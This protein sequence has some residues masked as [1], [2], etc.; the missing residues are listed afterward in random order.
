MVTLLERAG[1]QNLILG[2]IYKTRIEIPC[3]QEKKVRVVAS[4]HSSPVP[5]AVQLRYLELYW[6]KMKNSL[7]ASSNGSDKPRKKM[8]L[9]FCLSIGGAKN[10]YF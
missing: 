9:P 6:L 8:Q 5:L 3:M 1:M 2:H 7:L 10:Y 4:A